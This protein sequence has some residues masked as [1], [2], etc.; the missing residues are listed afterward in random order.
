MMRAFCEIALLVTLATCV[1]AQLSDP[2]IKT[3][4]GSIHISSSQV[5]LVNGVQ[6]L[7]VWAAF[8]NT[9]QTIVQLQIQV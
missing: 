8:A 2:S 7:D 5:L 6:V 3:V 4:N 9:M 1:G